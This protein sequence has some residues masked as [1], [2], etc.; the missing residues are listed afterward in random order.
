MKNTAYFFFAKSLIFPKSE[1]KSPAR[2][3]L[4]GAMLCIGLSIVPLIVVV[5]VT[6]GMIE[7]MTE[8]IIG[9]SSSHM[10]A[11]IADSI[12]EVSSAE[13]LKKYADG[14]LDIQGVTRTYPQ[15]ELSALAVGKNSRSGIE[16]RAMESD[17]F[18]KNPSFK[19]FFSVKEGSLE[20]Y[21]NAKKG[22]KTAVIGQKLA[23]D[24]DLH[25][26]DSFRII[27]T[28]KVNG[29][30]SPKLTSF[31]VAAVISSGYQELDQFWVFIP[32][33]TAYAALS[34][35]SASFGI[36]IET[37]DAFSSSLPRVQF[38]VREY[39]GRYANVYRWDEIHSAE[40]ENFSSTKVM[41]IFVMLLIVL[42][43]SVNISSAIIMLVMERRKEIAILK[44][45]GASPR[46][47]KLSFLLAGLSC[48]AG[49]ILFGLPVG[50]LLSVNANRI[51]RLLESI[52]NFFVH[53]FTTSEVK[54]L[55]PAYY[56]S[57][58]PVELPVLQIVLILLSTILLS[59]IVSY[60]PSKK[61]GREKPLDI[62]RSL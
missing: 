36:L 57:E 15:V 49:G 54:L 31:N 33:E 16:I 20:D 43:A 2:R 27:S 25:A 23:S 47:I 41:L 30:I 62:L 61:A 51:I 35:E 11:Y 5:S 53:F 55:D 56:L 28:R 34:L 45:L 46:G 58:I 14:L 50:L 10:Q 37:K 6:N 1:K 29:K 42:V 13:N 4:F 40:F 21:A 38:S 7:G 8:R 19:T 44:S 22:E 18:D 59:L 9:L 32:I 3:S 24:L 39:F 12:E 26:G 60:I 17:I 52:I 48:A